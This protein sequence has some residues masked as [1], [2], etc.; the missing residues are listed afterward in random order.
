M[1][2][3]FI[4][5][6]LISFSLL[7]KAQTCPDGANGV[8]WLSSGSGLF[9]MD[10]AT[11]NEAQVMLDNL[12]SITVADGVATTGTY[13]PPNPALNFTAE[14]AA[15]W[16]V[17]NGPGTSQRIR[18]DDGALYGNGAGNNSSMTGTVTFNLIAGGPIVCEYNASILPISLTKFTATNLNDAVLLEWQTELEIN[19]DYMAVEKSRDGKNYV[20]VG[21]VEGAGNSTFTNDY[22]LKDLN[23]FDGVNYYRLRQV[24]FDGSVSYSEII[25][26]S[27]QLGKLH[28]LKA[29]PTL[30]QSDEM[31]TIDLSELPEENLLIS[32]YS[33]NGQLLNQYSPFGA[34]ELTVSGADFESGFYVLKA[35]ST[36]EQ[37]VTKFIKK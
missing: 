22:S 12:V 3:I 23:P 21:N 30:L 33:L 9:V 18:P 27:I 10:W 36:N 34:E 28:E 13:A 20:E 8:R 17:V 11:A 7:L 1:K 5:S 32:I 4:G 19:N 26:T 35:E 37:Y 24:D 14:P 2:K 16:R 31:L 29:Y 25:Q 6:I 15:S